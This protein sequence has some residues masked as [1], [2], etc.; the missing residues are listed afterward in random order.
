MTTYRI[1]ETGNDIGKWFYAKQKFLWFYITPN[2]KEL[3][4][5]LMAAHTGTDVVCKRFESKEQLFSAIEEA[6]QNNS[7]YERSI[8][9]IYNKVIDEIT[10]PD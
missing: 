10:I 1:Y 2:L 4:D 3:R 7:R 8:S 9:S 6:H 5:D